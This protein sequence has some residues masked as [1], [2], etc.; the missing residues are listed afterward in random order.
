[1]YAILNNFKKSLTKYVHHLLREIYF[2]G[3]SKCQGIWKLKTNSQFCGFRISNKLT[4][5]ILCN[6][7][8][9]ENKHFKIV[10]NE[11]SGLRVVETDRTRP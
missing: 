3:L 9:T 11:W 7:W 6:R 5:P 4:L 10:N 1:M 8:A 2:L